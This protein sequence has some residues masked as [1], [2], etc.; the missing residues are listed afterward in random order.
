MKN[1]F[2][3]NEAITYSIQKYLEAKE[4]N[5]ESLLNSFYVIV[6]R[7]L[8]LIYNELDVINPFRTGTETGL[9]GF[10]ENLKKFGLS[11]NKLEEF[12][13]NMLDYFKNDDNLE[14]QSKSFLKIEMLLIDMFMLKKKHILM[15][16]ID[17][18]SFKNLLYSKN[19][20]NPDKLN[21]Y[22]KYLNDSSII[23]EYFNSKLFETNHNFEIKETREVLLPKDAYQIVGYNI[24]EITKMSDKEIENINSK[25]FHFF[26]IKEDEANKLTL[27]NSAIAY[28]KKYG[29]LLTNENA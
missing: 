5:D 19:D 22:K 12:K 16:D 10:N 1:N 27:L 28:Y 14:I 9:G 4:K 15:D 29:N 21:L 13:T 18:N 3:V 20:S 24:V 11:D 23:D 2:F 7:T 8:I 17:I 25:I 26:R 6:V